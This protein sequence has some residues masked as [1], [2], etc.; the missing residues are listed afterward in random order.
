MRKKKQKR[1]HAPSSE[2]MTQKNMTGDQKE[3][4]FSTTSPLEAMLEK[5]I[6]PKLA[7]LV[8]RLKAIEKKREK[9]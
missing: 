7:K 2:P 1:R 3:Q 6:P 5:P 8:E 9:K 4:G